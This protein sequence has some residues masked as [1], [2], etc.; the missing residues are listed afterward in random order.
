MVVTCVGS[1]SGV[2]RTAGVPFLQLVKSM[3]EPM[4]IEHREFCPAYWRRLKT[5][6]SLRAVLSP[7]VYS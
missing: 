1:K 7:I 4:G 3:V 6:R 2:G 5:I